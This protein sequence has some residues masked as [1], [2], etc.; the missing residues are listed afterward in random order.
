MTDKKP[1]RIVVTVAFEVDIDAWDD[2]ID[3]SDP[4]KVI[5]DQMDIAGYSDVCD[6]Q[7][8]NLTEVQMWL[9]KVKATYSKKER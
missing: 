3:W 1:E 5:V 6:F 9:G 8:A 7:N 4:Y 2:D